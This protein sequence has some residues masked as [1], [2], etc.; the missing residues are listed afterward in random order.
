YGML[1]EL[2]GRLPV[3]VQLEE[4][5]VD[6]LYRILTVPPDALA[7]EYREALALD[8]VEL[9]LQDGA[10][11]AIVEYSVEKKLGA[12]ALRSILEE[13]LADVMFDAP[14]KR[15]EKVAVDRRFALAR[16]KKLDAAALRD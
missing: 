10:L 12:R 11:K 2:L 13:V 15:G 9:E 16:L 4:L 8:G 5:T 7:R 6:E 14:E 1:A 3:Q